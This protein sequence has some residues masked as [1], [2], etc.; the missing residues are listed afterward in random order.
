LNAEDIAKEG[1]AASAG[2][3][4]ASEGPTLGRKSVLMGLLTSGFVITNAAQPSAAAA[5]KVKA[6]A[7]TQPA[8]APLWMPSTAYALG[9]QIISPNNDVVGANVAH[10]SSA[11]FT[12][13]TAKWTLSSTFGALAQPNTW[14]GPGEQAIR[15]GVAGRSFSAGPGTPISDPTGVPTLATGGAGSLT[16]AYKYAYNEMSPL[17][18]TLLSPV[19]AVYTAAAEMIEVTIPLPRRG[20]V[21]RQIWRTKAGG[22]T[23]FFVYDMGGAY[24]ATKWVDNTPDTSLTQAPPTANSTQLVNFTVKDGVKYIASGPDQGV[25]PADLTILT[26]DGLTAGMFTIDAYGPMLVRT[27]AGAAYGSHKTRPGTSGAI[28]GRHFAASTASATVG[29]PDLSQ[30]VID[31]EGRTAITPQD[32]GSVP[33]LNISPTLPQTLGPEVV[34]IVTP[35]G[36]RGVALSISNATGAVAS[37]SLAVTDSGA[38]TKGANATVQLGLTSASATIACLQVANAGSGDL[39]RDAGNKFRVLGSGALN[40]S[41]VG[42]AW[43]TIPAASITKSLKHGASA[44]LGFYGTTPI[45]KPT[46]TPAAA[47]DLATALT[48]IND[49]RAKLLALGVVG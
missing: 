4:G 24:F 32:D 29:D 11:T 46:G 30:F 12:D 17:G 21:T 13:D 36:N 31:G 3:G 34:K 39:I 6:I 47:T 26:S 8:Y 27:V 37:A 2:S 18:V 25:K 33:A 43:N 14:T 23:F 40:L 44:T 15:T 35:A 28:F 7:E 19:S 16:G 48:L 20:T 38:H 49:L 9:Q 10:T 45:V 5:G 41:G 42:A 22:S 1:D